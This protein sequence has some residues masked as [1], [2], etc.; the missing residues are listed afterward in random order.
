MAVSFISPKF[1]L[2]VGDK[3]GPILDMLEGL[4]KEK[5]LDIRILFWRNFNFG[6][7][8]EELFVLDSHSAGHITCT[9]EAMMILKL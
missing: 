6:L 5:G 1:E 7:G 9:M 3:K 8:Y 4:K 2:F